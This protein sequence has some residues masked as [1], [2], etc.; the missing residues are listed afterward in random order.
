M[1]DDVITPNGDMRLCARFSCVAEMNAVA[2][3]SDKA[4]IIRRL[5]VAMAEGQFDPASAEFRCVRR[6]LRRSAQNTWKPTPPQVQNM[7]R[8]LGELGKSESL[9][10]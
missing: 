9:I 2:P 3:V 8:I 7:Q 5:R 4:V 6:I 10:D 1:S